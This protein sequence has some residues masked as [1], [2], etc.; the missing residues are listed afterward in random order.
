MTN[1]KQLKEL[2]NQWDEGRGFG[3][4]LGRASV[5]KEVRTHI[6]RLFKKHPF[7]CNHNCVVILEKEIN[8]AFASL[9]NPQ[10]SDALVL[11]DSVD[12]RERSFVKELAD[13]I[14]SPVDSRKGCGMTYHEEELVRQ[15]NY[16][17]C[18]DKRLCNSCKEKK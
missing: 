16:W 15:D 14:R 10:D 6:D 12:S 8:E 9:N 3:Y 13:S 18:G 1:N 2:N 7:S 17:V 5:L 4:L 11:G